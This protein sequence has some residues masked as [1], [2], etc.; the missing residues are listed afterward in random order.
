MHRAGD[1]K[2]RFAEVCRGLP[3]PVRHGL[4]LLSP[5]A[6]SLRTAARREQRLRAARRHS[7]AAQADAQMPRGVDLDMHSLALAVCRLVDR[8]REGAPSTRRG[9]WCPPPGLEEVAVAAEA[10]LKGACARQ[11]VQGQPDG[12]C[13]RSVST[14][15]AE[16]H[17][18]AQSG[19]QLSFRAGSEESNTLGDAMPH[20][21]DAGASSSTRLPFRAGS[22]ESNTLGDA[23]PLSVDAHSVDVGAQSS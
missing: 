7:C 8:F 6:P 9:A 2:I 18:G 15:E 21:V 11:G 3:S 1:R 4:Q 19:A 14:A 5:M 20:S 23:A 10:A 22:E 16:W 13:T 17:A 12:P